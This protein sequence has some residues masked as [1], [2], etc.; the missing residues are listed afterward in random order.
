MEDLLLVK[1]SK[2]TKK[3]VTTTPTI[4]EKQY[5]EKYYEDGK[6]FDDGVLIL[7]DMKKAIE[8][9]EKAAKYDHVES[10]FRLG[11]IYEEGLGVEDNIDIAQKYYEKA[12]KLGHVEAVQKFYFKF[13]NQMVNV[14]L[15]Y[16][17][18]EEYKKAKTYF[19]KAGQLGI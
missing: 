9:Y 16:Q 7:K 5:I 15:I 14:G 10:L 4:I 12:A 18:F 11:E 8:N 1:M 6:K 3:P 2:Q 13:F 19:I 17:T